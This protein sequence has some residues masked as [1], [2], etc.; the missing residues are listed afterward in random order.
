VQP[1]GSA[2]GVSIFDNG[3]TDPSIVSITLALQ[4]KDGGTLYNRESS[5]AESCTATNQNADVSL[6]LT[7]YGCTTEIDGTYLDSADQIL[8]VA[9]VVPLPDKAK[10]ADAYDVLKSVG[11]DDWGI[12]CP[13]LGAGSQV[14]HEAWQNSTQGEWT[15]Y[16]HRY[17]IRAF[18]TYV[19]LRVA[20]A[21]ESSLIKTAHAAVDAIGPQDI[22]NA[23]CW[24]STAVI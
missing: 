23:N 9:W 15:A 20:P 4:F 21:L 5:A 17:L 13:D 14:C 12:W 10:A 6:A 7:A 22:P 11:V 19:D 2:T 18:A 16:C 3:A 8:V 24:P 1:S